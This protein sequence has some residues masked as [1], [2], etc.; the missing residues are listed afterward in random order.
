MSNVFLIGNGESRKGFDLN[1]LKLY[2][3]VYGCNAMY[4]D[5]TPDVLVSV[6]HGIMHE[7][8]HSGYCYNN[9]TW[10]RDWT[11]CP[12]FMYES[13]VYAGLSK[14]DIEELNKWHFKTENK[15][16]DEKEFVM[17]G[18]NLSGLVKIL[19]KDKTI[20]EKNINSNQLVISWVKDN[21]KAR[22]IND[23]MP[24]NID[25]GWAAGPTSGYIAT[26]QD[27]PKHVYLIGHDLVSNN[28]F[29]NN[30]YKDSKHYVISEHS[31][32]PAANWII[33][34]KILFE[35][36]PEINFYKVNKELNGVDNINKNISEWY[37]LKNLIYIDYTQ[38]NNILK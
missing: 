22:N 17:H 19:H 27:K 30:I 14:I 10:F 36:N 15:K 23:L 34:W 32:T 29:V 28:S 11:R 31:A 33:Q 26:K 8:Y 35:T 4:R 12:D 16:N 3:K 5:F 21:D 1:T 7:I 13:L 20:E 6:D 18:A 24:N 38:L 9:E 37:G 2:G 25:I